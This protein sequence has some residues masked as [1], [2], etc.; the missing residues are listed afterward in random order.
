LTEILTGAAWKLAQQ[1][2]QRPTFSY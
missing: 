1:N 2:E